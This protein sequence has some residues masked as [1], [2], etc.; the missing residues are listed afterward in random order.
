M[1]NRISIQFRNEGQTSAVLFSHWEGESLK[2]SVSTY[3]AWLRRILDARKD[4]NEGS[5]PI[6]RKEASIVMLDFIRWYFN[7]ENLIDG[8]FWIE[9]SESHGDNSDN[10]HWILDLDTMKWSRS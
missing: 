10:G 7:K 8:S 4:A 1:G 6:D 5:S 2:S 3:M 9:T